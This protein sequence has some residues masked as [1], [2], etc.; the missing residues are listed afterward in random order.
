MTKFIAYCRTI[1]LV[2]RH[3][4]QTVVPLLIIAI[5]APYKLEVVDDAEGAWGL[6]AGR[7]DPHG[8]TL[9]MDQQ[10]RVPVHLI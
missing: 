1:L 4:C 8:I 7:D 6:G 3:N 9:Q 5:L 10:A 2:E